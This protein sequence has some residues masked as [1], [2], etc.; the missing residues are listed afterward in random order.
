MPILKYDLKAEGWRATGS[1]F[2]NDLKDARLKLLKNVLN[3]LL[4][5]KKRKEV[6]NESYMDGF[7]CYLR[8]EEE[9]EP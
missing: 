5:A 9:E 1:I 6:V 2:Y 8:P 7:S 4:E 3:S